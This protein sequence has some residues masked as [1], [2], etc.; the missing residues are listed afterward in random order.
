MNILVR[1]LIGALLMCLPGCAQV[2]LTDGMPVSQYVYKIG[3]G[4]RLRIQ[5]FGEES[6]TGEYSVNASGNL[7]FPLIGDVV[8]A[9]RTQDAFR[10]EL[11]A[12]LGAQYL[13]NP[14]ITVEVKSYRPVF[15]LG[16]VARPGEFPFVEKLSIY[17]LVAKAG[18]FT[19]R[20]NQ[21]YV[22]IRRENEASEQAIR[23]SSA[24]AVQPGDTIR[25]PERTF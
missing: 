11:Q 20:A 13:R 9:G 6:L 22:F 7:A 16:E 3:A 17:A 2:A 15:I 18:G 23:L 10:D 5:V 8:A 25:I 12:K 24:T 4:D 1:A 14:Q 19:Y 21:G